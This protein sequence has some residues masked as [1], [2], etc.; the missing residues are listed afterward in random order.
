MTEWSFSARDKLFFRSVRLLPHSSAED[1]AVFYGQFMYA[2]SFIVLQE[3]SC[4]L[5]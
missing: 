4:P 2:G 3:V 1:A 5:L